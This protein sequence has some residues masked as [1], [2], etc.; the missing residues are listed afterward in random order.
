MKPIRV[1]AYLIRR[2]HTRATGRRW[3]VMEYIPEHGGRYIVIGRFRTRLAAELER[4]RYALDAPATGRSPLL[5]GKL[6]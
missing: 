1:L 6:P 5:L 2:A 4:A 3:C